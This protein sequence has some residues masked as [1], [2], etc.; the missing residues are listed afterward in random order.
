MAG[1]ECEPEQVN[2]GAL[3]GRRDHLATGAWPHE[4]PAVRRW[5]AAGRCEHGY[6]LLGSAGSVVVTPS[7]VSKLR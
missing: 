3:P 6:N 7:L 4:R 1:G 5:P 2:G